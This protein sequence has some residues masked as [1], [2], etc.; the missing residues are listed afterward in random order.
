MSAENSLM[1]Q[2]LMV[3]RDNN[4][5]GGVGVAHLGEPPRELVEMDGMWVARARQQGRAL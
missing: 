3:W 1:R 4:L 2:N 5:T